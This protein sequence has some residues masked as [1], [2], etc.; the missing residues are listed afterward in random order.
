MGKG[1]WLAL[2]ILIIIIILVPV[3]NPKEYRVTGKIT[4]WIGNDHGFG[5]V[6]N[7]QVYWLSYNGQ[8]V[9]KI[10]MQSFRG[11]FAILVYTSNLLDFHGSDFMG[12]FYLD[13]VRLTVV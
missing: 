7:G 2:L 6:I 1:I 3:F 13:F 12:M 9:S 4:D 8:I 5:L 11:H 10:P